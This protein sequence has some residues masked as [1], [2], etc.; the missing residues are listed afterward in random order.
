MHGDGGSWVANYGFPI[1][2]VVTLKN[3]LTIIYQN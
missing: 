2:A 1:E 3:L